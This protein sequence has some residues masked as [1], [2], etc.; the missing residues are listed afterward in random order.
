VLLIN[1]L[2]N[3]I[4]TPVFATSFV[5]LGLLY[6]LLIADYK[7]MS[8]VSIGHLGVLNFFSEVFV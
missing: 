3:R 6:H 4:K 8:A 2:T 5:D 1:L 7:C